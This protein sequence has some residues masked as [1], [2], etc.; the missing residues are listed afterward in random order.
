MSIEHNWIIFE[1]LMVGVQMVQQKHPYLLFSYKVSILLLQ[2]E[3]LFT[4]LLPNENKTRTKQD[5]SKLTL[6]LISTIHTMARL[7]QVNHGL[8]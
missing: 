6:K 2:F 1:E 7:N 8:S 4:R 3:K 5:I